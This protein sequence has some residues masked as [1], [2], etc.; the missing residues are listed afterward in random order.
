MISKTKLDD[1]FPVSQFLIPGFENPIRLNQSF[2]GGGMLYISEGTLLNY[3]KV[4]VYQPIQK[5]F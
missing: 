2:S 5:R 1:S 4:I 3:S